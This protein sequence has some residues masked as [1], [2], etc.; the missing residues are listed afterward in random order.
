MQF[1]YITEKKNLKH[2]GETAVSIQ[3]PSH[4]ECVFL[5]KYT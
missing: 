5:P 3:I 1:K 4:K 2:L